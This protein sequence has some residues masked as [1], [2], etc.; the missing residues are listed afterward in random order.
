MLCVVIASYGTIHIVVISVMPAFCPHCG[1]EVGIPLPVEPVY[2][3][4]TAALL[5]PVP[6]VAALVSAFRRYKAIIPGPRM[7]R[8]FQGRQYRMVTASEIRALR[9]I[10]LTSQKGKRI[11]RGQATTG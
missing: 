7:Y 1:H 6:S 11:H 10:Y 2:D 3:M 5:V 8:W 9:G 4:E